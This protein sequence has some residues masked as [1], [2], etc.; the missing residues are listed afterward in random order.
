MH[1]ETHDFMHFETNSLLFCIGVSRLF[2]GRLYA[3]LAL[4]LC[5]LALTLDFGTHDFLDSV[6]LFSD[7]S[8]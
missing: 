8:A 7:K 2:Y 5:T 1:F 6:T 3:L 4:T